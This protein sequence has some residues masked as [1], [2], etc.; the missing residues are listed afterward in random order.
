MGL[1]WALRATDRNQPR[2]PR[3]HDPQTPVGARAG[4]VVDDIIGQH[5]PQPVP[6][7]CVDGRDYL[8]PLP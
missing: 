6:D 3:R 8:P 2:G 4:L 7:G 1:S 5:L